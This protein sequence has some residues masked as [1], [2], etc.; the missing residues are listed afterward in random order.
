MQT[1]LDKFWEERCQRNKDVAPELCFCH[2]AAHQ[3]CSV[4]TDLDCDVDERS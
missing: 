2:S 3:V 1:V 4:C